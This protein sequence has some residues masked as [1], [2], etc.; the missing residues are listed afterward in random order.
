MNRC[1]T[2]GLV[3][4]RHVA[5]DGTRT[6]ANAAIK[7]LEPMVVAVEVNEYLD[8]LKLKRDT[9]R[10]A[11]TGERP[12]D[13][14]FPGE[15]FSN[16]IHRFTTDPDACL[17][18]TMRSPIPVCPPISKPSRQIK[19][20]VQPRSS[21]PVLTTTVQAGVIVGEKRSKQ[22]LACVTRRYPAH[23]AYHSILTHRV[24][25]KR[26]SSQDVSSPPQPITEG[27]MLI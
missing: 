26:H 9:S 8:L 12:D 4:G 21:A 24:P 16:D 20:T 13:R 5:F 22:P 11:G 10:C 23:T 6:R 7:S 18:R 15:K 3:S 25:G 27:I 14:N 19:D 1:I 17:Y 2:A